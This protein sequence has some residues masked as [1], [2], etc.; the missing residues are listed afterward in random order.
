MESEGVE[1]T[2][3]GPG[4][5]AADQDKAVPPGVNQVRRDTPPPSPPVGPDRINCK[6]NTM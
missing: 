5:I 2:V 4:R 1:T 6:I 3:A